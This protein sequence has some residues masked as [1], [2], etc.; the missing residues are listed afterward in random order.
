MLIPEARDIGAAMLDFMRKNSGSTVM[1]IVLGAIILVFAV[2]FG[3]ASGGCSPGGSNYAAI[4]DGDVIAQQD[5]SIL[6]SRQVDQWRQRYSA[7]GGMTPEMIERLGLKQQVIDGLIDRMILDNEARARGIVV[8]DEELLE[9]LEVNFGVKEVT[10]DQYRNWVG[11]VFRKPVRKFEEDIRAD[12][13]GRK[14][15]RVIT[16][17]VAVSDGELKD[18]F[19]REND[20]ASAAYVKFSPADGEAAEPAAVAVAKL[21]A[22]DEASVKERFEKDSFLYKTRRK[23]AARQIL[24]RVPRGSSDAEFAAA[25]TF[26]MGLKAQIENGADFGA[27]AKEHSQDEAS[28]GKGGDLGVV[29]PGQLVKSL[30]TAI[31]GLKAG[32]MVAAPV[33]TGLGMHLVEVTSVVEPEPR[34]F[35]DVKEKVA[36]SILKEQQLDKELKEKAEAFLARVV[37]GEALETISASEA[38]AR[39]TPESG[40]V[41]RRE[42]PWTLKTQESTPGIGVSADL[43][44][45]LFEATAE[46]P[47]LGKVYKVGKAYFVVQLK[48]R[49]VPDMSEFEEQREDL[50]SQ[51]LAVKRNKVY[52]DWLKHLR[53]KS[54]IKYNPA[55]FGTQSAS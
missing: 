35:A 11:N 44:K 2:N 41:V 43:H 16:D 26:L 3:P 40:L 12:I 30:Q 14:I 45:D 4:V 15:A 46:K 5:F 19:R 49:E 31:S 7:A 8:N 25:E 50:E 42:T 32:E 6:Y 9:F 28:A 13:R 55:I 27:L 48:E 39:E 24:R 18:T 1:Y 47:L 53:S 37:A 22:E 10:P 17:T 54:N 20:R 52:R 21:L 36:V 33:K 23:S 51:A 29:K 38:E 34:E